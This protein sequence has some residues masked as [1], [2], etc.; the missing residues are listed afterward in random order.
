LGRVLA[1]GGN[2]KYCS[3]GADAGILERIG[4]AKSYFFALY[5]KRITN[6]YGRLDFV[7]ISES[8]LYLSKRAVF[9][10]TSRILFYPPNVK[11][12]CLT[13]SPIHVSDILR[14]TAPRRLRKLNIHVH[15]ILTVMTDK[16]FAYS[17]YIQK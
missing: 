11:R 10:A 5:F 16:H 2:A 8:F 14:F 13:T 4:T 3:F 12:T 9:I 15:D 6:T 1:R 17:Y 7:R